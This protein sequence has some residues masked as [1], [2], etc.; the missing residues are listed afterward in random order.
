MIEP[1][2]LVDLF[3]EAHL[4]L[5]SGKPEIGWTEEE[6]DR[7]TFVYNHALEHVLP[8]YDDLRAFTRKLFEIRTAVHREVGLNE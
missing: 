1:S 2:S 6:A 7:I 4:K 3:E 5:T 8:H